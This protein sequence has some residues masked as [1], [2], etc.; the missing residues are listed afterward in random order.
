MSVLR[1]FTV[2]M[3]FFL[4]M[5][6]ALK[7]ATGKEQI[8][9]FNDD[10]DS[11]SIASALLTN[12]WQ[13]FTFAAVDVVRLSFNMD[14]ASVSGTVLL[15]DSSLYHIKYKGEPAH[16]KCNSQNPAKFC[17]DVDDGRFKWRGSYLIHKQQ[18]TL[19][20]DFNL[21]LMLLSNF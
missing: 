19:A 13:N 16:W 15:K 8:K 14:D 7:G 18:G 1:G 12:K 20:F 11:A 21:I 2:P 3:L 4:A 10:I 9:L 5:S 6:L 17:R